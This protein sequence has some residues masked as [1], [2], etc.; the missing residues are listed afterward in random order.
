MS[1][2]AVDALK[3]AR[4]PNVDRCLEWYGKGIFVFLL[5]SIALLGTGRLEF[6]SVSAWS[7]SRTTFLSWVLWKLLSAIRYRRWPP[8]SVFATPVLRSSCDIAAT[9]FSLLR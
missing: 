2:L 5:A 8:Y 3:Y 4:V 1:N 9:G 7:V 6:L